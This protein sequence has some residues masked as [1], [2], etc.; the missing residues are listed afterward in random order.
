MWLL[1]RLRDRH[2]QAEWMDRP[3]LD[4]GRHREALRGLERINRWSGSARILWHP[5]A[6][7]AAEIPGRPCRVLDVATGGGDVLRALW[8]RPPDRGFSAPGG[9]RH[10][11][12]GPRPRPTPLHRRGSGG[13]FLPGRCPE[14]APAVW[15]RCGRLF[16]LP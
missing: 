5:L 13:A 12:G 7:L 3:D 11:S 8:R 15:L 14:L 4:E 2:L 16:A 6:R 9:L 10:Q 1:S